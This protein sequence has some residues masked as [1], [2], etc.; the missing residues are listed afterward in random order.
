EQCRHRRAV[1]AQRLDARDA[2]GEHPA[3]RVDNVELAGDAVLVAQA[4]QPQRLAKRRG[5]RAF[6]VVALARARLRRQRRSYFA[7]CIADRLL[8]FRERGAFARL[9]RGALRLQAPAGED[10]L[11]QARR[12]GPH[13]RP[14]LAQ[15]GE[16]RLFALPLALER[17]QLRAHRRRLGLEL[18]QIE[19]RDHAGVTA[20]ALQAE[21][22]F[23]QQHRAARELN[24]LVERAQR[25]IRLR[26]LRGQRQAYRFARGL[27][28]GEVGPRG[29]RTGAQAPEEV[30]FVGQIERRP[31]IA[32]LAGNARKRGGGARRDLLAAAAR[33][34]VDP[35]EEK[36]FGFG[37]QGTRLVH[38]R[39]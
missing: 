7:E 11:R 24:L 14:A 16:R 2:G 3:L 12:P 26:H 15:A 22:L 32:V 1:R 4:C 39:G 21:R 19:F 28:R 27:V 31:V 13:S 35:R 20:L 8:V 10:R 33:L 5:A 9:R 36:G 17:R 18:A 30:D 38:A 23:A 29:L 6:G 25:E 37:H 34:R